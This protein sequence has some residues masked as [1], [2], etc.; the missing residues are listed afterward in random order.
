[1]STLN[2][3]SIVDDIGDATMMTLDIT[4]SNIINLDRVLP[5]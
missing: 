5:L 4:L 3:A 2:N 1:M